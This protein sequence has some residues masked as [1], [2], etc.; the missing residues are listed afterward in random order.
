[1]LQTRHITNA[2]PTMSSPIPEVLEIPETPQPPLRRC[3]HAFPSQEAK[4]F[5]DPDSF[6]QHIT[7]RSIPDH[8]KSALRKSGAMLS[9][10]KPS[11][12]RK[13]VP[14][15]TVEPSGESQGDATGV[16][17]TYAERGSSGEVDSRR[18]GLDVTGAAVK[19]LEVFIRTE[20]AAVARHEKVVDE[21]RELRDVL[22]HTRLET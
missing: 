8:F 1:M 5:Q 17:A 7:K 10:V 12:S 4:D 18:G 21:L 20:K 11:G 15:R 13:S 2:L 16:S 3:M 14:E 19:A 22:F 6:V 9:P